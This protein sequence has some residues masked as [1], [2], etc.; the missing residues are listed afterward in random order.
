MKKV[1][2]AI[3]DNSCKTMWMYL[4]SLICTFKTSS[5]VMLYCIV[6]HNKKT[7]FLKKSRAS[8]SKTNW[9]TE[10]IILLYQ[11]GTNISLETLIKRK[12]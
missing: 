6:Y 10:L 12:S 4:M 7:T 8:P 3:S 1:L 11:K 2:K 5:N 9:Y